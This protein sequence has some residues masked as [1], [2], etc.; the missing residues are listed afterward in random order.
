VATLI[1]DARL[2]ASP[3]DP[4][5]VGDRDDGEWDD[6]DGAN[7]LLDAPAGPRPYRRGSPLSRRCRSLMISPPSLRSRHLRC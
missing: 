2:G 4:S 7:P 3:S 5:G 1:R 6:D